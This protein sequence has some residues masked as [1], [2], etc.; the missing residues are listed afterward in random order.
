MLNVLNLYGPEQP[1]IDVESICAQLGNS[2]ATAYRYIRE[3]CGSGLLVRLP[4]GYALGPR[5]I[6]LDLQM[7]E[8][9]PIVVC[10]RDLIS[11]MVEKTGL[12]VLLSQ[13][14]GDAVI[15]IHQHAGQDNFELRFGRGRPMSFFQSAT[16]RVVL[17]N[18]PPRQLRRIYDENQQN[19]AVQRLGSDWKAFSKVMLDIRKKGYCLTSGE[20]NA[21]LIGIAS[22][23]FDE[24][25]RVLGSVTLL[26][27]AERFRALN[28][29]YVTELICQT[30]REIT[31]RIRQVREP[32][33]QDQEIRQ[34]RS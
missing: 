18:L 20:L 1:I 30:S 5:V 8:Y 10:S 11:D 23:I 19:P 4:N 12:T 33:A 25:N 6:E 34:A 2:P 3:L 32:E 29:A 7:R 28:N 22:A 13:L 26:G 15:N 16:A 17:A 31:K 21:G 24:E 14:Y 9:D 27:N